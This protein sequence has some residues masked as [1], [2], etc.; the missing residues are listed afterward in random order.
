MVDHFVEYTMETDEQTRRWAKAKEKLQAAQLCYGHQLYGESCEH[1]EIEL[2]D[3][4]C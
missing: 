2:H 1:D 4:E 3:R